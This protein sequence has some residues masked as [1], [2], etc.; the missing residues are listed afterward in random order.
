MDYVELNIP[1][2]DALQAEI[3]TAMLSDMPFESF[4][5]EGGT[6]KAY[7]PKEALYTC[8]EEADRVLSGLGITGAAYI[9]IETQNWNAL[10]ESNFEPVR[11]EG[12]CTIRAPFSPAPEAGLDIVIMPKMSFGTGHHATTWLMVSEIMKRDLA[13]L[14]CLDMGS[15]TGVLAIAAVKRGASHVDAVD[16]DEWAYENCMEN[17]AVNDAAAA[18]AP[19]LGDVSAIAGRSYNIIF[20]NINR[21]ILLANMPR[22]ADLLLP[23]GELIMSGFLERDAPAVSEGALKAGMETTGVRVKDGWAAVVCRRRE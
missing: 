13:G 15:G 1:V 10:W 16:I 7:I 14:C 4:A 9:E 8:K 6:L 12:V 20:A 11:I 5:E 17:I 18:V 21:N 3:A 19:V 22:Y 23:G 2:A